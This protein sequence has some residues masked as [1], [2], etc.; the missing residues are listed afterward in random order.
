MYFLYYVT[1]FYLNEASEMYAFI[2]S[3]LQMLKLRLK[4]IQ[5]ISQSQSEK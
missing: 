1:L 2:I 3:N 5:Y 4:N